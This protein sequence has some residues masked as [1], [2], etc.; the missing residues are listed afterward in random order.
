MEFNCPQNNVRVSE[1]TYFLAWLVF[2]LIATIGGGIAG[3]IVGGVIGF[4]L[5]AAGVSLMTIQAIC[6]VL[7]FIIGI[8]ISY[9][10]FRVVVKK[11]VVDKL[12]C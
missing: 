5:G 4:I 1:A 6:T 9:L 11:M 7:G 3:L 2:F 10:A 12:S 8:P